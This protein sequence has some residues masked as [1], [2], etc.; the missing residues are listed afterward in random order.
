MLHLNILKAKKI[1]QFSG[2]KVLDVRKRLTPPVQDHCVS[3]LRLTRADDGKNV[4]T[5][6]ILRMSLIFDFSCRGKFERT[7]VKRQRRSPATSFLLYRVVSKDVSLFFLSFT[8]SSFYLATH[9]SPRKISFWSNQRK[10]FFP[11]SASLSYKTY[12]RTCRKN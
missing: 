11:P 7:F 6:K 4:R 10:L 2:H 9:H 1:L 8:F 5:Y 12:V 3:S